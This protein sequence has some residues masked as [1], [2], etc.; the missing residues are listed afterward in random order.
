MLTRSKTEQSRIQTEREATNQA[1][2]ARIQAKEKRV[3]DLLN[4]LAQLKKER[5]VKKLPT[6]SFL[7]AERTSAERLG[8][9]VQINNSSQEER[10]K[11]NQAHIA[12]IQAKEESIATLV[13]NSVQKKCSDCNNVCFISSRN[14]RCISCRIEANPRMK[15]KFQ[16]K[17]I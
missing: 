3:A 9:D 16:A 14:P 13:V 12:R 5:P 7:G 1:H 6:S 4:M 11:T 15:E 8:A 17:L 2:I 10:D